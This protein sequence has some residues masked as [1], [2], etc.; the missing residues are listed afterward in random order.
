MS[1]NPK[2]RV[3]RTQSSAKAGIFL[4]DNSVSVVG[5]S[6]NFIVVDDRG[7]TIKGPVSFVSDSINRR[8]AGLF[9]G[10]NDFLELIP[11]T[12]I[13]P[14]PSKIPFPPVFAVNNIAMDLAFFMALLI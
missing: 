13:T 14:I 7:V 8:T 10:I 5:D 12:I 2:A 9:V 1:A 11:Q 3:L 6:R 4:E